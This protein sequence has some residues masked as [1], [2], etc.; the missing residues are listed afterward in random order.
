VEQ[1]EARGAVV[2]GGG[3]GI[4]RGIALALAAKGVRVLVVDIDGD[5]AASVCKE[6]DGIGGT[7][8]AAQVDATDRDALTGLAE[9]IND[10]FGR[11][12]LLACTV[13]ILSHDSV[14][15]TSDEIWAWHTD[16]HLMSAVRVVDTFLPLLRAHDEDGHIVIT[17]SMAGLLALP[18]EQTGGVNT[19]VYTVL[20]HAL[21]GYGDMLRH[22][23]SSDGIGV[24]ILCPGAVNTNLGRTTARHRPERFGGPLPEPPELE[25]P[26]PMAMMQPEEVGRIVVR[27]IQANRAHILSDPVWMGAVDARQQQVLDDFAFFGGTLGSG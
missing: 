12:H 13:G 4:G 11:V 6:I 15:G 25:G 27:G 8:H 7:A 21:V 2:V 26:P 3:S 24:S 22:E 14:T 18:V 1:L 5:S 9:T 16:F 23:V 20:K 19:G 17:S 10:H